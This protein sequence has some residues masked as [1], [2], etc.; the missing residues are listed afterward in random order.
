MVFCARLLG[1]QQR[2]QHT[3]THVWISIALDQLA[4]DLL[5]IGKHSIVQCSASRET[6]T[7]VDDVAERVQ[8]LSVYLHALCLIDLRIT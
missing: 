1:Q 8:P 5:L 7:G 4:D 3:Y 2:T 6:G